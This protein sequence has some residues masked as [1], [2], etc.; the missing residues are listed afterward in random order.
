M[1][2]FQKDWLVIKKKAKFGDG[3][4]NEGMGS[5]GLHSNHLKSLGR[6]NLNYIKMMLNACLSYGFVAAGKLN[7]HIKPR[8]KN[9]F[10]DT[11]A[12]DNYRDIMS[13]TNL[14]K[15]L[16]HCIMPIMGRKVYVSTFLFGYRANTSTSL[17]TLVLKEALHKNVIN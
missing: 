11:S 10:G 5:D 1:C 12:S 7:S 9:K 3:R 17:A 6:Y 16:E 4:L 2:K 8:V 13:S 14:F 15:L